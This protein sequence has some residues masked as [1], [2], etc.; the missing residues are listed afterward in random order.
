M[1]ITILAADLPV[2]AYYLSIGMPIDEIIKT[3]EE[4][5]VDSSEFKNLITNKALSKF[6]WVKFDKTEEVLNLVNTALMMSAGNTHSFTDRGVVS[7]EHEVFINYA[8]LDLIESISESEQRID[9]MTGSKNKTILNDLKSLF[10]G[11]TF[12][13]LFVNEKEQPSV[14]LM[15]GSLSSDTWNVL[16]SIAQVSTRDAVLATGNGKE[17]LPGF[18][19]FFGTSLMTLMYLDKESDK[20]AEHIQTD[21]KKFPKVEA[22]N[23]ED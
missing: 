16:K 2:L 4:L 5:D 6:I 10:D 14:H 11:V 3:I 15:T 20:F 18:A 8:N 17:L 12:N 19:L 23:E 9:V 21:F 13:T 1:K 7:T 22:S